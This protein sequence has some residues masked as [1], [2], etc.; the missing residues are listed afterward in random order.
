VNPEELLMRKAQAL[1]VTLRWL[2]PSANCDSPLGAF[3][4]GKHRCAIALEL[5]QRTREPLELCEHATSAGV[6]STPSNVL[7]DLA[8]AALVPD[9]KGDKQ[10][11]DPF[12]WT[13]AAGLLGADLLA[14]ANGI[15]RD[16]ADLKVGGIRASGHVDEHV[17]LGLLAPKHSM[18]AQIVHSP[19]HSTVAPPPQPAN[20]ASPNLPAPRPI[21]RERHGYRLGRIAREFSVDIL[22]SPN[23]PS[24]FDAAEQARLALLWK[25][26]Q[27]DPGLILV[28]RLDNVLAAYSKPA[29][30]RW[31]SRKAASASRAMPTDWTAE[32]WEREFLSALLNRA[33]GWRGEFLPLWLYICARS[34]YFAA[35]ESRAVLSGLGEFTS[36]VA[37]YRAAG[38]RVRSSVEWPKLASRRAMAVRERGSGPSSAPR[39]AVG[40]QRAKSIWYVAA[41]RPQAQFDN[42]G[43][44]GWLDAQC[45][46][47]T[48]AADG[49]NKLGANHAVPLVGVDVVS[50]ELGW[51]PLIWE[52]YYAAAGAKHLIAA[53]HIGEDMQDLLTGLR[54]TSESLHML[55]GQGHSSIRLGHALALRVNP[56]AWYARRGA[57]RAHS[58]EHVLDL[59]WV[60]GLVSSLNHPDAASQLQ[61]VDS[62]LAR[63]ARFCPR[64]GPAK[65][66]KRYKNRQALCDCLNFSTGTFQAK[67][68]H[69][70]RPPCAGAKS[71]ILAA[72]PTSQWLQLVEFIQSLV[73]DQVCKAANASIEVCPT[74]NAQISG[75]GWSWALD[76]NLNWLSPDRV[77][78][79]SD[80]PGLLD[81]SIDLEHAKL[82]KWRKRSLI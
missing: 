14:A 78:V 4:S 25:H 65:A 59:L 31:P 48:A 49:L 67:L 62:L 40:R 80:D 77:L 15:A 1:A 34:A 73:R 27:A 61:F 53:V 79:G 36:R 24:R 29:E 63:T 72:T 5:S 51:H 39:Q 9:T 30:E 21:D 43:S 74:S 54:L 60:R 35:Q 16:P 8:A 13:W 64:T 3:A 70:L 18:W 46:E 10:I 2:P 19:Q 56:A 52:P 6:N 17:H 50:R 55:V 37:E 11:G 12:L 47:A 81:T 75:L 45:S 33:R 41:H 42:I 32:H 71:E 28:E 68:V 66:S 22:A 58:W 20:G 23:R 69:L 38:G 57:V 44:M 26:S 7:R 82:M 76:M